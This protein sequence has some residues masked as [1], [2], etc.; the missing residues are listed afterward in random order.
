MNDL[1]SRQCAADYIQRG[2]APIP[3]AWK[4]KSPAIPRWPDLRVS[5]DQLDNYFDASPGNIGVLLGEPS[6][7]LV[8]IDLDC[9]EAVRLA[10]RFLPDTCRFG[11]EGKRSSHWLFVCKDAKTQK[12]QGPAGMLL[13]IRSTGAQ[14]L[15]PGSTHPTGG[16]ITFDSDEIAPVS[17][18]WEEL[19]SAAR[20]LAAASLLAKHWP[21][22]G[23]R[24]Q[25][26][27][28][29]AGILIRS[30]WS[31]DKAGDFIHRVADAADDEEA[32]QRARCAWSTEERLESGGAATGIPALIRIVGEAV[33]EKLRSWLELEEAPPSWLTEMNERYFVV[34]ENGRTCVYENARAE[35]LNRDV[36]IRFE[37]SD[38]K[39]LFMNSPVECGRRQ[40]GVPIVKD[41]ATAWLEHPNRHQYIDGITFDPTESCPPSKFNL[42][43]GFAITPSPGDWRLMDA[44]L[45]DVIC[46]GVEEHYEYLLNWFARMLQRPGE[47]G[48]VA[49]VLRG[50]KGTGK[51]TVGNAF[52][53]IFG[54]HALYL[55]NSK[56]LTGQFNGHLRDAVYVFVDEAFFAGDKAHESVLKGLITDP[57]ITVEA[58]FRDATTVK[59]VT[60]ILMASN[61][62]WVVPA[63]VDERRYFV[64]EV[65]G[66]H[67]QDATYFNALNC[68]MENGGL[69]AMVSDLLQRDIT[70]FDVRCVP[71][72][73][74]LTDQKIASL[75]GPEAW[76]FECLTA[77]GIIAGLGDDYGVPLY[78]WTDGG[79]EVPRTAAYASY[80]RFSRRQKEYAPARPS[81][82]M[83]RL[84]EV[85]EGLLDESRPRPRQTGPIARAGNND[86]E[87]P[88]MIGLPNLEECRSKFEQFLGTTVIWPEPA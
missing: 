85:F 15:F 28:A 9:S 71:Q 26:A 70:G 23:A 65:D 80:E 7:G 41:R 44:H 52:A 56:H 62:S 12:F 40:S 81:Q 73:Q 21:Q 32:E 74:A 13:E 37:F 14:T 82:W 33:V 77:G 2:W 64:L 61:E 63:S 35:L 57:F 66:S 79:L 22:E 83:K 31:P 58:K 72:T 18:S 38:L 46:C 10:P 59:N 60:H 19:L 68:E 53:K 4:S 50:G 42:W 76:L 36:L 45:R 75:R 17:I 47:Q 84:R 8:D 86:A 43:R 27:L 16:A 24:H 30:G 29:L 20:S 48:E 87:R 78:S 67:A 5:L 39:K 51:G 34:H 3:I 11:R 1:T 6:N 69:S 54:Q 55:T 25:A 88:R 49:V